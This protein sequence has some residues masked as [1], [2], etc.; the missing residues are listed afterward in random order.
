MWFAGLFGVIW[1]GFFDHG[2]GETSNLRHGFLE[3]L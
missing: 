3:P 1:P 2:L